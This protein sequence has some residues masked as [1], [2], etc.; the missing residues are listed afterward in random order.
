MCI[1]DRANTI[2]ALVEE[3]SFGD[4]YFE[5]AFLF[6]N[7]MLVNSMLSSSEVLYGLNNKHLQIL[8]SCDRA[9]LTRLF[10]VPMTCSYEAVYM[11]TGLLPIRSILL[12][13]RLMYYWT[14]LNKP[15]TELVKKVFNVQKEHSVKDLSLIHI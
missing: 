6:R 7:S 9:L 2:I 5:M 8:E 13:R 15:E 11:E 3:I 12:G 1:R 10:G 14:L 4:H